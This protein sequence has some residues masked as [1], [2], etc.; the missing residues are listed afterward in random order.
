[1]SEFTEQVLEII[2]KNFS[3]VLET[4]R[5]EVLPAFKNYTE[6]IVALGVKI[7]EKLTD[8]VFLTL[9]KISEF[10]DAHQAEFKKLATSV[11][12]VTQDLGRFLVK[13]YE[14]SRNVIATQAR[15]LYEEIKALPI[16][17]DVKTKTPLHFQIDKFVFFFFSQME[18]FEPLLNALKEAASAVKEL[19]PSPEIKK[20][21]SDIINYLE[22]VRENIQLILT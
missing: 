13:S 22:K 20:L 7:T 11:T 21:F 19:I 18:I 5:K 15:K 14:E 2:H 4:I 1:M 9:A 8:I 6:K 16:F 12:V 3:V 17:N 10:L